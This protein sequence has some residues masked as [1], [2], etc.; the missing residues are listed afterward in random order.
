MNLSLT[1]ATAISPLGDSTHHR[2]LRLESGPCAKRLVALLH[3]SPNTLSL[4]FADYPYAAKSAPLT[5]ATDSAD[6]P[7]DCCID[8]S[9]NITVIYVEQST[10]N[11]VS[12]RLTFTG[13]TWSIG[14]KVA[15]CD[16]G[17]CYSPSV[18]LEPSGKLWVAFTRYSAPNRT[19]YVKSSTDS[20]A[21]WGTGPSDGGEAVSDAAMFL[22]ARLLCGSNDLLLLL[23]YGGIRLT[24]RTRAINGS[25]WSAET[26]LAASSNLSTHFDATLSPSGAVGLAFLEAAQLRYRQFDGVT[27]SPAVT[28]AETA[29]SAQ[30]LFRDETPVIIFLAGFEAAQ[31]QLN[32]VYRSGSAFTTPAPLDLRRRT[33]DSVILYD[34]VSAS[35]ADL[36][37][38]AAS[39]DTADVYHPATFGLVKSVGDCLYLGLDRPFRYVQ[40]NLFAP[41][42]GGTVTYRYWDGSSWVSFTPASGASHLTSEIVRIVLWDDYASIPLAWQKSS[43]GSHTCFWLRIDVTSSYAAA[44]V[45]SRIA[46]LSESSS[47]SCVRN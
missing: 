44:P 22:S 40:M 35:H 42:V 3:T 32:Y 9:G 5:V 16:L 25:S 24:S 4:I 45:A 27:W 8:A 12:R 21:T 38:A 34:H 18:A 13:S 14:E 15:A 33:F 30:M 41:G 28:V 10:F 20:G 39:A 37:V 23:A 1:A 17:Q 43:V 7:F 31:T 11:L 26:Q 46:G 47:V 2:L 29:L 36:T 6:T 19:C